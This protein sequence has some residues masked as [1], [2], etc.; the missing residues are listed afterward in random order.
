MKT[1]EVTLSLD[2]ISIKLEKRQKSGKHIMAS[3]GNVDLSSSSSWLKEYHHLSIQ[4]SVLTKECTNLKFKLLQNYHGHHQ[5]SKV[6]SNNRKTMDRGG[7]YKANLR[8][9]SDGRNKLYNSRTSIPF[10][11]YKKNIFNRIHKLRKHCNDVKL[12]LGKLNLTSTINSTSIR[13][14]IGR[15]VQDDNDHDRR[16]ARIRCQKGIE[17]YE[18]QYDQF[19]DFYEDEMDRLEDLKDGMEAWFASMDFDK[20]SRQT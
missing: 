6:N 3:K 15:V 13:K 14:Q 10:A 5:R 16:L 19:N 2:V 18:R 8:K 7:I 4:A 11:T 9:D 17:A 12:G 20:V 1:L